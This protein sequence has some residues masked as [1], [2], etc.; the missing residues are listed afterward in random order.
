[1]GV[2]V[3][4]NL[5][6]ISSV[7]REKSIKYVASFAYDFS[8]DVSAP[9]NLGGI[10]FV[11]SVFAVDLITLK[12]Q[13]VNTPDMRS[14]QF[15]ISGNLTATD[16]PSF[17]DLIIYVPS[18]GQLHR[19]SYGG[20]DG[21]IAGSIGVITGCVPIV[22]NNPTRVLFGKKLDGGGPVVMSGKLTG[23]LFSFDLPAYTNQGTST[24]L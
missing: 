17:G 15:S 8:T 10:S 1:M 12:S 4:L 13:V 5:Q 23:S 20:L 11:G 6:S 24:F 3:P 9:Q 16:S 2:L 18:S 14:L 21:S 7:T 22:A 19:I